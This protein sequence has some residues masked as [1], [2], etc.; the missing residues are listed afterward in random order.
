MGKWDDTRWVL[1]RYLDVILMDKMIKK[2]RL[3]IFSYNSRGFSM[4]KQ[5]VC[6]NL[7]KSA[8]MKNS[9]PVLCNQENFLLKGN[10]YMAE[11]ALPGYHILFKPAE[12]EHLEGRPKNGMFIAVP[13]ELKSKANEI[14]MLDSRIQALTLDIGNSRILLLN[15]Y[16]PQDPKTM[17][18]KVNE[19]LEDTLASISYVIEQHSCDDVIIT[20]DMNIDFNR[21]NGHGERFKRF[22]CEEGLVS[23]WTKFDV[24]FTH[25]FEIEDQTFTCTIDHI[26]CNEDLAGTVIDAGVIHMAENTSDHSPIHCVMD[27]PL[28]EQMKDHVKE[29][30]NPSVRLKKMT[31]EDWQTY[32]VTLD[33]RLHDIPIPGCVSCRDVHCTDPNHIADINDYT[34]TIL[35]AMDDTIKTLAVTKEG[36]KNRSKVIPGWNDLV[37]P[38][39]DEA[40]FWHSI[41]LSAGKPLNTNLHAIMKRTRN[42]YHYHIRKCRR[43]QETV[44]KNKLLDA[45]VNGGG[46]IFTELKKMRRVKSRL[47][48][49]MDGSDSVSETFKDVY[50]QLYTSADDVQETKELLKVVNKSVQ[51][52]SLV[53][54]DRVTP[55]VVC[56]AIR[57]VKKDKNDPGFSFNSN[58]FKRS[59][60]SLYRHLS[61]M[62]KCS[63]VHGHVCQELLLATIVPLI[64]NKLGSHESSDNYRSIALSSVVLKIFDWIVLL[65]F[66]EKLGFDELQFSY[67]NNC[68]TAMCTWLVIE[69]TDYFLR[70]GSNVYSCFMDMRKA[71]DLVKHSILFQKLRERELS[72]IF[73]RLIIIMY[74]NQK[75]NVRWGS[76]Y[77]EYFNITNGVKQ[78]AVLSAV[79]FCIY[80]D[81]LIKILRRKRTG[82]WIKKSFVGIA[83]YADDIVL[84]S[85]SIDGLQEMIDTCSKY[86]GEHNLSFSTNEDPVK[87]KTKCLVFSSN[88]KTN[89]GEPARKML[90]NGKPL[91]W[92]KSVKHLG[93]KINDKLDRGQD[94]LE[95]RA[96]YISKCNELRQEFHFAAPE[97]ITFLNRTYNTHFY[98]AELWDLFS[99]EAGRITGTWNTTQRIV[100]GLP[101]TTHRYLVEPISKEMHVMK[102]LRK[103]FLRFARSI[104]NSVK[105]VLRNVF[106]QIKGECRS[107]TG[108]N[109]R[110][111]MLETKHDT[112]T[113][114]DL[115]FDWKTSFYKIPEEE[116]WRVKLIEVLLDTKRGKRTM[117]NFA[118]EDIDD[119]LTYAS[120]T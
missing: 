46:E 56:E 25:E 54:V 114:F 96:Q 84:L 30:S 92:V 13:L 113:N 94:T 120:V 21:R 89:K 67:Q 109:L 66:G 101:R 63:L 79:L 86:S 73:L 22:L 72:P 83:V 20:G 17:H 36:I 37:K 44:K 39:K 75:A 78:G 24:D 33:A 76:S 64:K 57:N 104:K 5:D 91:P 14:P 19:E 69:S 53:D 23:L 34:L 87:S 108:R 7:M 6:R 4:E 51:S 117:S 18:Y 42:V 12:K 119:M 82:C 41:W 110:S 10:A 85:P 81:D 26:V 2:K 28:D 116:S 65:L 106:G 88:N 47:P 59:P 38:F 70:N 45:C 48:D 112:F 16:F 102:L 55:E 1:Y 115:H 3:E 97:T 58:C 27:I 77:S 80:I 90:L 31:E 35:G 62:V 74:I 61:E 93:V 98:G 60:D 43:S 99:S 11:Q 68:N 9:L 50:Q 71:F 52:S 95:K 105:P 29:R 107:V 100:F 32:G 8:Q 49:R 111:I 40:L 15:V 118:P 103:R